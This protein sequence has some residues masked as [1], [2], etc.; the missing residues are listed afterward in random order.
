MSLIASQRCLLTSMRF[1]RVFMTNKRHLSLLFNRS[2]TNKI[3]N[4]RPVQFRY[5][6]NE[7]TKQTNINDEKTTTNVN[8]ST[9]SPLGKSSSEQHGG[10]NENTKSSS[11]ENREEQEAS[12]EPFETVIL[13]A[14]MKFVPEYGFT[15]EAISRG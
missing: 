11:S 6:S 5:L 15:D 14:A 1:L 7:T 4:Y 10:S 13:K 9:A 3:S 2:S 12:D 8:F